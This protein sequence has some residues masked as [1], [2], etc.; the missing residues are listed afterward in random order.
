MSQSYKNARHTPP[1]QLQLQQML[2]QCWASFCRC[3]CT[4]VVW[5]WL[6]ICCA[7]LCVSVCGATNV[8][9]TECTKQKH[10]K[11]K[12][13]KEQGLQ[14][15]ESHS[16]EAAALAAHPPEWLLLL[17]TPPQ[18]PGSFSPHLNQRVDLV[19]LLFYFGGGGAAQH[20]HTYNTR[21]QSSWSRRPK[22]D[23]KKNQFLRVATF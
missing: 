10:Q 11:K 2:L 1:L 19:F 21:T 15:W 16:A 14:D 8:T 6:G 18:L 9:C 13:N 17:S 12:N 23:K 5:L 22:T 4:F 20:K 7:Y 3:Y